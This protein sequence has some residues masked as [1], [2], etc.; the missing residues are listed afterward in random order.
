VAGG[1]TV[2]APTLA[3]KERLVTLGVF[4]NFMRRIPGHPLM[5]QHAGI[6]LARMLCATANLGLHKDV[7][8]CL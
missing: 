7:D 4:G 2:A 1:S 8:S 3:T 5:Q 6:G